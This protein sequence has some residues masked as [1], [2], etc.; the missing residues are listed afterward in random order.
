MT[1]S[2]P[3]RSAALED[4][5]LEGWEQLGPLGVGGVETLVDD[6]SALGGVDGRLGIGGIG[7]PPISTFN[8]RGGPVPRHSADRKPQAEEVRREGLSDLARPEDDVDMIL[9]HGRI[10]SWP[11]HATVVGGRASVPWVTLRPFA[12]YMQQISGI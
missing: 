10:L 11:E 6:R 9:A 3:V 12:Q 8:Q 4:S 2:A 1:S 7:G 5:V